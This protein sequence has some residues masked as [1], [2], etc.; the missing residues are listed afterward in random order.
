[1]NPLFASPSAVSFGNADTAAC[2]LNTGCAVLDQLMAA[3][4]AEGDFEGLDAAL[5]LRLALATDETEA[6]LGQYFQL[7]GRVGERHYLACYRLRRWLEG[8]YSALVTLSRMSPACEVALHLDAVSLQAVC[9]R[10]LA[11][12]ANGR[13]IPAGARVQLVRV[14]ARSESML[15]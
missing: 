9:A 6:I 1:M 11:D 7:R 14:V 10:C 8:Q 15:A 12:A 2:P 3:L 5:D 4:A 13:S